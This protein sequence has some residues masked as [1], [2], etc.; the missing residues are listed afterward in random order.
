MYTHTTRYTLHTCAND[1]GLS[2]RRSGEHAR[3]HAR[4]RFTD[5]TERRA[6]EK[7][8]SVARRNDRGR[9][10]ATTGPELRRRTRVPLLA[11]SCP[12]FPWKLPEWLPRGMKRPGSLRKR[13]CGLFSR[14]LLFF[15]CFFESTFFSIAFES[16]NRNV[17]F[18]RAIDKRVEGCGFRTIG[19]DSIGTR[20]RGIVFPKSS[21]RTDRYES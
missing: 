14:P 17:G 19:V 20:P 9:K 7:A 18:E 4:M 15:R 11:S 1:D 3:T 13:R 2:V 5:Y 10:N 16:T 8:R 12:F 21:P 6:V